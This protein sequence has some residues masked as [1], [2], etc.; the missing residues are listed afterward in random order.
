MA[1]EDEKDLVE[2]FR[3]YKDDALK[4]LEAGS[5]VRA[6]LSCCC[7]GDCLSLMGQTALARTLYRE[8]AVLYRRHAGNVLHES[9]REAVWSYREAYE[10]FL[11]ASETASAET[12]LREYAALQRKADPFVGEETQTSPPRGGNPGAV[13]RRQ[14]PTKE[15]LS[16]IEREIDA[17]LRAGESAEKDGKPAPRRQYDQG[18]L[19][20]E[21][22][23]AG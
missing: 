6:A 4:C 11:L 13:L 20:L 10:L 5:I 17:L 18:D 21:K 16:E 23:I 7:A 15:Q 19:E 2:A 8:A 1:L 3:Q 22:S 14:Q 12:A 9:V